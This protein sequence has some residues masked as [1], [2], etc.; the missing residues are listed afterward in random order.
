MI[1]INNISKSYNSKV[2]VDQ[3]NLQIN[4]E[5]FVFL[6]P[7]GAGKTTTIKLLTGLLRPDA[8][9]IQLN[10]HD[11]Q[12]EPLAAKRQFGYAPET[13][14]LYEKLTPFEFVRLILAIYQIPT[15]IGVTRMEQLF[16][17]FELNDHQNSLIEELSNGMKKKISLIAALVHQPKILILDEPTVSL[18]PK[19]VR[20]LKEIMRGMV[21]RGSSVFMSTHI[22]EV[23]E[24]MADR[25]G[26]IDHGKL[27]ALGTIEELRASFHVDATLEEIFL[28]L[29]GEASSQKIDE[30]LQ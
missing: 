14:A 7:N 13:P 15:A 19:A 11:I 20:H 16:D 23:A 8:G 3:L 2:A 29:T 6:G 12:I 18:D 5:L 28:R 21:L 1:T 17:I 10:G 9:H 27:A 25:I 24:T 22:L 4:P 30:F 26:I